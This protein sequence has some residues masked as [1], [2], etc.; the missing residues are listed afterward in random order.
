M[1]RTALIT[2]ITGQ[3]GSYLA[4]F[5]LSKGYEVHGIRRRGS[6]LNTERIEHLQD[7]SGQSDLSLHYGDMADCGNLSRLMEKIQPDEVY[8]LA[9]QSDV[10][11]SFKQPEYTAQVNAVGVV[12]LLDAVREAGVDAKFYQAST[13]EMFGNAVETPQNEDTP[14][15]PRSPYGSSKLYAYWISHNYRD[16]YDI[17]VS[18]GILFNHESPRRGE[19]FVTRKISIGVAEILAG[20][21]ETIELGN[22][23]ARRDWGYAPEYVEAMW[24]MLQQDEPD[25]Y[26]IATEE[27]H[28]VRE[29]ADLAFAHAGIDLVWKGDG[30]NERGVDA[31]TG[32]IRVSVNEEYFRPAEVNALVGDASKAK[33]ELGWRSE[34]DFETLI[35]IIVRSDLEAMDVDPD[36]T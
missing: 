4:E 34:T 14:F 16:A 18:N 5:L 20:K 24:T 12:R 32:D 3:D 30:I 6:T 33:D 26:V 13:S 27:T 8:N 7:D 36:H 19:S 9:A 31:E 25:D 22:L 23:D 10:A 11:V 17:F 35:E 29:F 1:P 2:G 21:R 28:T 15:Q